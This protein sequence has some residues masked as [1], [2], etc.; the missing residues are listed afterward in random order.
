VEA[1]DPRCIVQ[2]GWN[3]H[4]ATLFARRT[5]TVPAGTPSETDHWGESR[6][7]YVTPIYGGS[8]AQIDY[9]LGITQPGHGCATDAQFRYHADGRERP[10]RWIGRGLGVFGVDGV[11]AGAELTADQLGLTRALMPASTSRPG[12]SWWR[13]RWRCRPMRRS[14]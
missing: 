3:H 8:A 11:E 1:H 13:R 14:R 6:M 2:P 10:L 4:Q 9:R 12:S 5:L 7:A